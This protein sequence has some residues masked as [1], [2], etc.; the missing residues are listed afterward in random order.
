M[1]GWKPGCAAL[2]LVAGLLPVASG[3]SACRSTE[4]SASPVQVTDPEAPLELEA[5]LTRDGAPFPGR[6][7]AFLSSARDAR[8]ESTGMV[9][10]YGETGADGV[11]RVVF[12]RGLAGMALPS[13]QVVGYRVQFETLGEVDGDLYCDSE[14][15]AVLR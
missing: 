6:R 8:G 1:G 4:L 9:L 15:E 5:R 13:Q 11:A 2:A 3:C 10:G 12:R 7:L 14:T